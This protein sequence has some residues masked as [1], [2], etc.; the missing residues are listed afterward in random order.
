LGLTQNGLRTLNNKNITGHNLA[1]K[2]LAGVRGFVYANI[3]PALAQHSMRRFN[4]IGEEEVINMILKGRANTGIVSRST[5]DY[6]YPRI[7]EMQ[8]LYISARPHDQFE[9]KILVPK[10]NPKLHADIE[11]KLA[12]LQQDQRWLAIL[13]GYKTNNPQ[14]ISD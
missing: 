2:T 7:S 1:G 13:K 5:F 8:N 11:L 12:Q 4:T 10:N 3:E 6:L 14:T 9:R